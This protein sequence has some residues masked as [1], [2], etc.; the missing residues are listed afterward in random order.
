LIRHDEKSASFNSNELWV[1]DQFENHLD[2]GCDII[3]AAE[4]AM[5]DFWYSF[6]GAENDLLWSPITWQFFRWMIG[7]RPN[8]MFHRG[9][10]SLWNDYDSGELE[11]MWF[12][13]EHT[14]RQAQYVNEGLE[15]EDAFEL[16][17]LMSRKY[18][19]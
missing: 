15:A 8:R 10:F 18:S 12:L 3:E 13:G 6:P 16:A 2:E 7:P 11:L 5:L 4:R 9:W 1:L 19:F 17:Y 14:R